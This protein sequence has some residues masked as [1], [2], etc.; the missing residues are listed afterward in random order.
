MF[1]LCFHAALWGWVNSI[2]QNGKKAWSPG[3]PCV[4]YW[5]RMWLCTIILYTFMSCRDMIF[6]VHLLWRMISESHHPTMSVVQDKWVYRSKYVDCM[7]Y[8]TLH[9]GSNLCNDIL[10]CII[11][12]DLCAFAAWTHQHKDQQHDKTSTWDSSCNLCW[13][14]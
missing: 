13:S 7:G 6:L 3:S 1:V 14:S 2:N 11:T 4:Q 8:S 9:L 10:F 12:A 5:I